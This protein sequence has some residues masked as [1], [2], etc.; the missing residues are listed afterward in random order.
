MTNPAARYAL[1]DYLTD[2]EHL[3]L[4]SQITFPWMVIDKI[5]G[6]IGETPTLCGWVFRYGIHSH[7]K[8]TLVVPYV[9][10]ERPQHLV[11]EDQTTV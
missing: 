9:N 8:G 10:A 3:W 4:K 11:M 2:T 6:Q 1:H 7:A 5:T